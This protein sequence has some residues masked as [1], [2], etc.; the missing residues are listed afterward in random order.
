MNKR[1]T[2]KQI[3]DAMYMMREKCPNINISAMFIGGIPGETYREFRDTCEMAVNLALINKRV[4]PQ[5]NVYAPYPYCKSYVDAVNAGWIPPSRTEDW[6]LDSKPG[7]AVDAVW[8][9]HYSRR[10]MS[11]FK[12]TAVLFILLRGE[13]DLT[14]LK[15]IIKYILRDIAIFRLRADF[16]YFPLDLRLFWL[17]YMR[18]IKGDVIK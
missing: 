8:L 16:Y 5:F 1:L 18:M 12:W 14:G 15:K 10:L 3:Y 7:K 2:N 11:K 17:Y 13:N 6:I 4:L 9:K